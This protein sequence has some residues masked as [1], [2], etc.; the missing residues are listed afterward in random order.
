MGRWGEGVRTRF[1]ILKS[2]LI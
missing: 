2:L 1:K